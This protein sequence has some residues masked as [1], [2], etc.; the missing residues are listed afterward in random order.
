[1]KYQV[2]GADAWELLFNALEKGK[3]EST[4]YHEQQ[5]LLRIPDVS[6]QEASTESQRLA[7]AYLRMIEDGAEG[8]PLTRKQING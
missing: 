6:H 3:K 4:E 5:N 7:Q 2:Q 8:F 1:M